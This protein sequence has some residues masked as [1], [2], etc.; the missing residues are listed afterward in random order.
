VSDSRLR[1]LERAAAQGDPEAEVR[2][3]TE[4]LRA[5][6]RDPRVEPR[7]DDIVGRALRLQDRS[8]V[9]RVRDLWPQFLGNDLVARPFWSGTDGTHLRGGTLHAGLLVVSAEAYERSSEG[10]AYTWRLAVRAPGLAPGETPAYVEYISYT[11]PTLERWTPG[12]PLEVVEWRFVHDGPASNR[13]ATRSTLA[14]WR[15][16]AKGGTVLRLGA[17]S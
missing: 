1:G 8:I 15:R 9:R 16:W 10:L 4:R 2:A 14:H 17:D 3:L 7:V 13:S 6:G 11:R 12:A 5:G